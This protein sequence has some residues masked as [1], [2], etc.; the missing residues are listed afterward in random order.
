MRA[1][2]ARRPATTKAADPVCGSAA[3]RE[4]VDVC[5]TPRRSRGGRKRM[6]TAEAAGAVGLPPKA[7]RAAARAGTCAAPATAPAARSRV[8]V[9]TG[10]VM[11]AIVGTSFA[12]VMLPS[13]G[14]GY[15]TLLHATSSKVTGARAGAQPIYCRATR[16][17]ERGNHVATLSPAGQPSAR[18][19][20]R[21]SHP[22]AA[23]Y[24]GRKVEPESVDDEQLR[25]RDRRR[26]RPASTDVD[27]RIGRAVQH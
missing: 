16:T 6:A 13:A 17:G 15:R 18:G 7:A 8:T 5:Q 26:R 23:P 20:S 14:S 25:A 21:R 1:G 22:R 19:P 2:R 11:L 10:V 4:G 9:M 12:G 27:E 24:S 3:S